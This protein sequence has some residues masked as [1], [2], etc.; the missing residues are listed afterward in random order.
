MSKQTSEVDRPVIFH[1]VFCRSVWPARTCIKGVRTTQISVKANAIVKAQTE[2]CT[3]ATQSKGPIDQHKS[4]SRVAY[5]S[6]PILSDASEIGETAPPSRTYKDCVSKH[7]HLAGR[8][9]MAASHDAF[10]PSDHVLVAIIS[11]PSGIN[12]RF[13]R[14]IE[15]H[16]GRHVGFRLYVPQGTRF[17]CQVIQADQSILH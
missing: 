3:N 5:R 15:S 13:K 11:D 10:D 16:V 14:S 4:K 17:R 7:A 6:I 12:P 8:A 9:A 1:V 2:S